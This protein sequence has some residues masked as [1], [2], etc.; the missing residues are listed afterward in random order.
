M[1]APVM[2]QDNG[3]RQVEAK[4]CSGLVAAFVATVEAIENAGEVFLGDADGGGILLRVSEQTT[5]TC[6][7]G[8]TFVARFSNRPSYP[9]RLPTLGESEFTAQS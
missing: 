1:N 7:V 4:A 2:H 6:R 8:K 9:G 3:P 5:A